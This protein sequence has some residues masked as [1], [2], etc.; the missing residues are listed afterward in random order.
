M[1]GAVTRIAF[2]SRGIHPLG[3]GGI[4]VQTAGACAALAEVADVTVVT[5]SSN[6]EALRELER[7][8]DPDLPQG[9]RFAFVEEPT[10]GEFGSYYSFMHLYSAR[11]YD[12][13]E[14]LYGSEGVDIIEFADFLGEALVTVQARRAH[15]P[16]LRGTAVC[17]RLHTSAEMCSILNGYVDDE[18]ETRMVFAGERHVLRYA[19]RVLP[20]SPEVLTTYKRFYGADA[21]AQ[22]A[23]IR[24][25]VPPDEPGL[26][27]DPPPADHVRFL[28]IGR[29]ERRK[30]VQDL[31]RAA[32]GLRRENWSLTVLGTDTDTAPLGLSMRDQLDLAAAE[33]PR[34]RFID[35]L[36]RAKVRK[37]FAEHD[38]VVTPSRW[39]CWPSVI[40]EAF[41]A[42]RPVIAT[43]TGG[44]AEMVAET[45]AGWLTDGR[46]DQPLAAALTRVLEDRGLVDGL[47]ASRV[48]GRAYGELTNPDV[49]RAHY[50]S[51]ASSQRRRPGGS[52]A[53]RR[54]SPPL[55]S[56]V[57]PYFRLERYVE[58]TLRSIFEQDYPRLEVIVVND[59]SLRAQDQVLAELAGRYPIRVLTKENAGLGRARNAGIRQSRGRY[60]LPVDADNMIHPSFVR[61]CV[62]IL[63]EDGS[64]AFATTWSLY[65]DEDG[66]P[67]GPGDAGFQ[68]LGNSS[69]A[70]LRDNVAGD[71][72]AVIRRRIFD[73]GHWYSPDLTSYEDWQF[74]REL[75]A[76]GLYGRVIPKRLLLYRV[77]GGS[78]LRE[79]GLPQVSRLFGEMEAQ[80]RERQIEWECKSD[81]VFRPSAPTP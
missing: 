10:P 47:I 8:S 69:S 71:A 36:P 12:K 41:Q 35:G 2:V 23:V 44:M 14:E 39:E 67:L 80:L 29:L 6:Q 45:G 1:P 40:L 74:Y 57:V 24:P 28:Y 21:L 60:V 78:M 48:P 17:V 42:N 79:V 62:E 65:L 27:A 16:F 22:A 68:P 5:S 3:G 7:A 32:T 64:V 61:R 52:A 50:L 66:E 43:P 38:V 73:L 55:V 59:G 54:G 70:V 9:V 37:L 76:A 75:H 34:I 26:A 11:V 77:R 31:I 56:V 46:L 81:S 30:G 25:V 58:D 15:E 19:D 51:L 18:F 33:H 4:G 53:P 20:P 72:T 13:L 63:E 49:F